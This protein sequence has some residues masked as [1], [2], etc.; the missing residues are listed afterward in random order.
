MN[1]Q[2]LYVNSRAIGLYGL[3][4]AYRT[5]VLAG[6]ATYAGRIVDHRHQRRFRIGTVNRN[7]AYGCRRA[8]PCTGT[9]LSLARS[10]Q[11]D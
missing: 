9:A 5:M 6:S 2:T 11:T 3:H 7:H 1:F 8:V 10:A 4:G